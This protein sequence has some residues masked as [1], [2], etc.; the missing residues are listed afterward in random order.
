MKVVKFSKMDSGHLTLKVL[1]LF[2]C[3]FYRCHASQ[4]E[5]VSDTATSYKYQVFRINART[6]SDL[7]HVRRLRDKYDLDPW[8]DIHRVNQSGDFLVKPGHIDD[9]TGIL[10]ENWI[11]HEIIIPDAESFLQDVTQS[12][13][14]RHRDRRDISSHNYNLGRDIEVNFHLGVSK[15]ENLQQPDLKCVGLRPRVSPLTP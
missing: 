9:V 10:L 2:T 6:E 8:R 14:Y 4:A 7:D 15:N 12:Q 5:H 11:E 3:T 13:R 1:V